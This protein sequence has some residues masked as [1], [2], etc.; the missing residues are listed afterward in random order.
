MTCVIELEVCLLSS[1]TNIHPRKFFLQTINTGCLG[2][3][4]C[5]CVGVWVI[6]GFLL[7][8]VSVYTVKCNC[9]CFVMLCLGDYICGDFCVLW[10]RVFMIISLMMYVFCG[11]VCS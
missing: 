8:C 9:W 6:L 1:E 2:V 7:L 4:F 3:C 5:L 10:C 11:A